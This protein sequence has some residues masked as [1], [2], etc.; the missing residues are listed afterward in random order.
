MTS[1]VLSAKPFRKIV[2]WMWADGFSPEELRYGAIISVWVRWFWI[3]GA[4]I[5]IN[6]PAGYQDRYYVLNTLYVLTPG[7]VNGYVYYWIKSRSAVSARWLLALSGLDVFM[8]SFSVA[9][10]GGFESHFYPVYLLVLAMFSVVF[11]S[12]R[13]SCACATLVAAVY[14]TLSWTV[15]AGLDLGANDE[16]H[17]VTRILMMYAVACAVSLIARYERVQR[18]EAVAREQLLQRE[19]IELSQTIHDTVGQSAYM[20]GIGIDNAKELA[21]WTNPELVR[22]LEATGKLARSAMWSLRHPTDIGV[23]FDGQGLG[24]TLS[25][26]A[27][28]FTAITSIP[29]EVT[30]LGSEPALAV[31]TKSLLFSIAHNAMTNVFRHAEASRVEIVLDFESDQLRLSIGD[32]GKGLPEDYAR[33]GHGFRN[34]RA[35]AEHLGGSLYV[36]DHEGGA[37][38]TVICSIPFERIQGGF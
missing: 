21:A 26:H 22:S 29:A 6:Y 34:M 17:L 4:L 13:L 35:D 16:K 20:I 15:G 14:A 3:I 10:S 12:V 30:Q 27:A 37:G 32:D 7:V 19:R 9:M 38:T 8:T 18:R 1:R 5:E 23:I 25:S 31:G 11:T 28:T 33:R 2:G 24:T 36:M